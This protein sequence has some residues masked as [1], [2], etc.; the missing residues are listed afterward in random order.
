MPLSLGITLAMV[1]HHNVQYAGARGTIRRNINNGTECKMPDFT[2]M[3]PFRLHITFAA[4]FITAASPCFAFRQMPCCRL[5][6]F[7]IIPLFAADFRSPPLLMP[8]KGVIEYQRIVVDN[9]D[10]TPIISPPSFA[11]F[12]DISLF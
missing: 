4:A 2:E 1:T 10:N 12:A 9:G 11:A 5:L 7:I 6:L 3:M 8:R